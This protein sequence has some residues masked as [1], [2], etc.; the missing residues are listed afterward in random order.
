MCW[1]VSGRLFHHLCSLW[2]PHLLFLPPS[3]SSSSPRLR[4]SL[5]RS[6]ILDP[7]YVAR[8]KKFTA[9]SQVWIGK[10]CVRPKSEA[11]HLSYCPC[12]L[13]VH[14]RVP[15]GKITKNWEAGWICIK[16]LY[17]NK[18]CVSCPCSKMNTGA[19]KQ[20]IKTSQKSVNI[21]WSFV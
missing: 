7:C 18:L 16:Q 15:T 8:W 21:Y 10:Q 17:K 13:V 12:G 2:P 1:V 5:L 4:L 20:K 19:T 14:N 9:K 3:S 11:L 6:V